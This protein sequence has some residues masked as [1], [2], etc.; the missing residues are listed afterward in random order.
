[1]KILVSGFEPFGKDN[2][3]ANSSWDSVLKIS[4]RIDDAEIIKVRLP[5]LYNE[6]FERLKEAILL[7]NPDIVICVGQ[8]EGRMGITPEYFALNEIRSSA[9]DNGGSVRVGTKA[10]DYRALGYIT[11]LPIKNMVK[12]MQ[13]S[14][15]PA[16]VSYSAGGYVCNALMCNLLY[17]RQRYN[18]DLYAGFIHV[19]KYIGQDQS[20][21][22]SNSLEQ[23]LITEGL[24]LCIKEAIKTTQTKENS[25]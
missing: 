23:N 24:T 13:E 21:N 8:A 3:G 20:S 16:Y 19:P 9:P 17:Y 5:V 2:N 11:N 25:I 1:M 6:S 7:H 15:I 22:K 12:T 4:D 10:V 14:G 18:P